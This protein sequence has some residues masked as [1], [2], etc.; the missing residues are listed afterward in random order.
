MPYKLVDN[1]NWKKY[2]M[3]ICCFHYFGNFFTFSGAHSQWN[4]NIWRPWTKGNVF[5]F[6]SERTK[7]LNSSRHMNCTQMTFDTCISQ[8]L[9]FKSWTHSDRN[10]QKQTT[11]LTSN[12]FI[13][14][15][16]PRRG[17]CVET[18]M[19]ISR[20]TFKKWLCSLTKWWHRM[21]CFTVNQ[22]TAGLCSTQSQQTLC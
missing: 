7:V 10:K 6:M 16:S 5:M 12:D 13:T 17:L 14:V 18:L 15:N 3:R 20:H 4:L 22:E 1:K 11:H 9:K 2:F 21:E 19:G 8:N